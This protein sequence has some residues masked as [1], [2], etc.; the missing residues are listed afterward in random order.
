[1]PRRVDRYKVLI[2]LELM[3]KNKVSPDEVERSLRILKETG[4]FVIKKK[5]I[6]VTKTLKV[7]QDLWE[8]IEE[9]IK[10]DNMLVR[11]C[12]SEA[13]TMWRDS[14]LKKDGGK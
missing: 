10:R 2:Y 11:E 3:S 5:H 12:I 7:E 14:K 9:I 8:E 4:N 13:L 1:M 6:Y